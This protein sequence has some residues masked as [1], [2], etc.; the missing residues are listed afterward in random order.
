MQH[1]LSL[2]LQVHI[3]VYCTYTNLHTMCKYCSIMS[4]TKKTYLPSVLLPNVHLRARIYMNVWLHNNNT[5]LIF[6]SR[7]PIAHPAVCKETLPVE[8]VNAT[9]DGKLY[10]HCLAEN[11]SP[12]SV[13]IFH[14]LTHN[15]KTS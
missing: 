7:R 5:I 12:G 3:H 11:F 15:Q 9:W 1:L 14:E 4:K 8:S 6:H 13:K 10:V 2:M